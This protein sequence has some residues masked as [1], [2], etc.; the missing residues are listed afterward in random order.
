MTV[1][2]GLVLLGHELQLLVRGGDWNFHDLVTGLLC[3]LANA[4]GS[5][6]E[7]IL[8]ALQASL[9]AEDEGLV[10]LVGLGGCLGACNSGTGV[11]G[12]LELFVT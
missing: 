4:D 12:L 3:R 5:W 10:A 1:E 2:L 9:W 8:P 11:G 6:A 7:F